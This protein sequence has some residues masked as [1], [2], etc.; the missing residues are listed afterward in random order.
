MKAPA[1]DLGVLASKFVTERR[2]RQEIGESRARDVRRQLLR[3]AASVEGVEL[4]KLTH[5]HVQRFM[6]AQDLA[7]GSRYQLYAVL[8]TFT[9]WLVLNRYTRLDIMVGVARPKVPK[10]APR[11]LTSIDARKVAMGAPDRRG[12]VIVLLMLQEGL[13]CA[14]V[15]AVEL[16]DLD[17]IAKTLAVR[18]KGGA[19]GVTRHLALTDETRHA[20][21]GYLEERPAT[22]GPLVRDH[23]FAAPR[24]ISAHYLTQLVSRWMSDAGVKQRPNDGRSAH[25]CR[26]TMAS[27]MADRG[28]SIIEIQRALGHEN[29]SSTQI[30]LRGV[31]PDMRT[32]MT[33]RS[34]LMPTEGDRHA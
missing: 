6:D 20:I 7:P 30:Y 33:G 32:A 8:R 15:A 11:R 12:Q 27:D 22:A 18:G 9:A 19:G 25:A 29:L 17:L 1:K 24:A 23:R 28:A 16:G 21:V 5:R 34:Y 14:E 26:H 31:T 3:F 4:H 13:R 10:A 2:Q